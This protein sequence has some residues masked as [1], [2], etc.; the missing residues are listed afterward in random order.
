MV[1]EPRVHGAVPLAAELGKARAVPPVAV[2]PPVAEER[3]LGERVE[4]DVEHEEEE[5]EHEGREGHH[6]ARHHE[7]GGEGRARGVSSAK[8]G[9]DGEHELNGGLEG[10][11]EENGSEDDLL[12]Q[13]ERTEGG[14]GGEVGRVDDGGGASEP[15]KV[16][17]G[18][19]V[20]VGNVSA[21]AGR[22]GQAGGGRVVVG[23][24]RCLIRCLG[25]LGRGAARHGG[26]RAFGCSGGGSGTAAAP[27]G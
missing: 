21:V 16:S 3:E 13:V 9:H 27:A 12:K 25:C 1:E 23:A 24:G 2:E 14:R 10:R 8:V 22:L 18:D 17:Q 26:R 15:D 19:V 6:H 5:E 7:A 20:G 11:E 4:E